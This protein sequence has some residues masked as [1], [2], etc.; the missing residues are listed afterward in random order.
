MRTYIK[1]ETKQEQK[2]CMKA[3]NKF[4]SFFSRWKRNFVL[5]V[6]TFLLVSI[7]VSCGKSKL[8]SLD[9]GWKLTSGQQIV[10]LTESDGGFTRTTSYYQETVTNVE[11]YYVYY[12]W[13]S[14]SEGYANSTYDYS[15]DLNFDKDG[16]VKG[17]HTNPGAS[18]NLDGVWAIESEE[19]IIMSI[20]GTS[21]DWQPKLVGL[22]AVNTYVKNQLLTISTYD[23]DSNP[24]IN[25]TLTFSPT[26]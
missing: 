23:G 1:S 16:D 19:E 11:V 24:T 4:H 25:T 14:M 22:F 5:F 6:S 2:K 20:T 8:K 15:L 13:G 9:G 26:D 18:K 10:T 21:L 7:G 12:F 3:Q 17:S